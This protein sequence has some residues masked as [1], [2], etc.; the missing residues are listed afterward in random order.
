GPGGAGVGEAW[1]KRGGRGT[2][3]EPTSLLRRKGAR[4]PAPKWSARAP[5]DRHG[6]RNRSARLGFPA[7]SVHEVR[8]RSDAVTGR[9]RRPPRGVKSRSGQKPRKER[10]LAQSGGADPVQE[11]GGDQLG[12]YGLRAGG[13]TGEKTDDARRHRVH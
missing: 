1:R 4:G 11:R 9:I 12:R 13:R 7:T 10:W 8:R 2:R 3:D 5:A 6:W